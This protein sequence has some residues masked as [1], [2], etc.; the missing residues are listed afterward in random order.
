MIDLGYLICLELVVMREQWLNL[1]LIG[2]VDDKI[3][4]LSHCPIKG[5]KTWYICR[6][7]PNYAGPKQQVHTAKLGIFT[8]AE[9]NYTGRVDAVLHNELR[10]YTEELYVSYLSNTVIDRE[11][12]VLERGDVSIDNGESNKD[13]ITTK[14]SAPVHDISPNNTIYD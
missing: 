7:A 10:K 11:D 13:I 14:K 12:I 8:Y 2:T 1:V 4:F 3:N 6:C 9:L 5:T